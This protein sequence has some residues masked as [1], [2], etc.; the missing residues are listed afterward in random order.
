MSESVKAVQTLVCWP[1]EV[2]LTKPTQ[3]ATLAG[4]EIRLCWGEK[5]V[6]RSSASLGHYG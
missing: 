4:G 1:A 6:S 3:F 2:A 5:E